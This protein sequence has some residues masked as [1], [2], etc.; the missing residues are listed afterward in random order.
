MSLAF[1]QM[2][3]LFGIGESE[4]KA[5]PFNYM[6]EEPFGFLG[7]YQA[8]FVSKDGEPLVKRER[9]SNGRQVRHEGLSYV[10]YKVRRK[11]AESPKKRRKRRK[12]VSGGDTSRDL[13]IRELQDAI[14]AHIQKYVVDPMGSSF[15]TSAY[16]ARVG[17]ADRFKDGFSLLFS[18]I[19]LPCS[20]PDMKFEYMGTSYRLRWY[21]VKPFRNLN[22]LD[23][24][25]II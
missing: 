20:I 2:D 9:L 21:P 16:F 10:L 23:L 8:E 1:K 19:P 13:V 14:G 22:V 6:I 25:E 11:A 17:V 5:V 15:D 24:L 4:I 12:S 7:A 18:P 3:S